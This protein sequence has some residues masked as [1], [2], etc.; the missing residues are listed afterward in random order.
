MNSIDLSEYQRLV[1]KHD[2]SN[3]SLGAFCYLVLGL[4]TDHL[5]SIAPDLIG[6]ASKAPDY[7][8]P[9]NDN[10]LFLV[11]CLTTG[12]MDIHYRRQMIELVELN[13]PLQ[14]IQ[15][16]E[17]GASLNSLK[18]RMSVGLESYSD[19]FPIMVLPKTI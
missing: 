12:E 8:A 9:T 16:V 3:E 5:Q 1:P 7:P 15:V 18:R 14:T 11:F 4:D 2:P 6:W 19:Y 13:F 17:E 10:P